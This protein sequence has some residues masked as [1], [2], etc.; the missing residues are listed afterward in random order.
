MSIR[1]LQRE[2]KEPIE[3]LLRATDV[4][5]EEE[6]DVAIELIRDLP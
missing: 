2:D 6:I 1:P 4:F 5:S 3:N